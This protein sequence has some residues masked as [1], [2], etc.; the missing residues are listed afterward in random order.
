MSLTRATLP[1]VLAGVLMHG[2]AHAEE[3]CRLGDVDCEERANQLN[4]EPEEG[5]P[6]LINVSGLVPLAELNR[7]PYAGTWF[8][9]FRFHEYEV[10]LSIVNLAL[11]GKVRTSFFNGQETIV[12]D[13]DVEGLNTYVG[14]MGTYYLPLVGVTRHFSVGLVPELH[15]TLGGFY[16][17]SSSSSMNDL[18]DKKIGTA[19]AVPVY[20][21]AR[22]GRHASRYGD[23]PFSLGAGVGATFVTFNF[24]EPV[25][26]SGSFLQPQF[27]LEAA[28]RSFKLGYAMGLT[29]HDNFSSNTDQIRLSYLTQYLALSFISQP[30]PEE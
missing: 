12:S 6:K 4:P 28:Y 17:G 24:G 13:Q 7:Q 23:W 26:D 8:A 18:A 22:L 15:A 5:E 29:F 19:L 2:L 10:G 30:D 27:K 3:K 21:M 16:G 20:L 11:Q 1:L 9:D 14:V 25:V